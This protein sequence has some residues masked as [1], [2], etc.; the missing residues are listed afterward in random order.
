M[1]V[2]VEPA[3]QDEAPPPEAKTLVMTQ[4][5]FWA[6]RFQPTM[7]RYK[8]IRPEVEVQFTSLSGLDHEEI[9]AKV[10]SLFA[11]GENIDTS[12]C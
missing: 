3:T 6:E 12:S 5:S 4:G 2:T 8:E 11:A 9:Y 10:L 1:P 7:E